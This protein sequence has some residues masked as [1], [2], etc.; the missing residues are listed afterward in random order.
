MVD[1]G[2]W[3]LSVQFV[4]FPLKLNWSILVATMNIFGFF[5]WFYQEIFLLSKNTNFY[6]D[7]KNFN[8][9]FF[10]S[11]I[12]RVC[13]YLWT[14][15]TESISISIVHLFLCR[16][17]TVI[18]IGQKMVAQEKQ[19]LMWKWKK[20]ILEYSIDFICILTFD[21]VWIMNKVSDYFISKFQISQSFHDCFYLFT[22]DT[23]SICAEKVKQDLWCAGCSGE[24]ST[25]DNIF[26]NVFSDIW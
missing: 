7:I 22:S 26:D 23:D 3:I 1:G 14:C 6:S 9:T 15:D 16:H 20:L 10:L 4:S 8:S 13:F 24:V 17:V 5:S 11:Q 12:L 18:R 19:S 21:K 25:F 2:Q